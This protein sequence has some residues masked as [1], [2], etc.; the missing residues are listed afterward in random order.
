MER[1][2]V[3]KTDLLKIL[4]TNRK[5]H[6]A[7]YKQACEDY[8][9][10]LVGILSDKLRDAKAGKP[11]NHGISLYT[12]GDQTKDYDRA[13]RMLELTTDKTISL[14]EQ[15]FSEL[16]QDE[17]SWKGNF[18]LANSTLTATALTYR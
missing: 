10:A 6:Q 5:K 12:P 2:N 15:E 1:V 17:W 16:V 11:V 9:V 18:S 4:L 3:K 13:I 8:K 7:D 14:L